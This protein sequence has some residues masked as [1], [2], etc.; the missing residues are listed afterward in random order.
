MKKINLTDY[1]RIRVEDLVISEVTKSLYDYSDRLSEISSLVE[2]ISLIGQQQPIV[3]IKNGP[4]YVIIDGVLRYEAMKRLS[5]N[6]I[7]GIVCEFTETNEFSLSD[8]IIHQQISKQ[9][10][11]TE[12]L[13]EIRT[14]LRVE[15]DDTNPLRDKEKRVLLVSSLL[16]GKGWGRN[17]VYSLDKILRWEVK[18]NSEL[19]LAEKVIANEITV[20]KAVET[21][22][23]L[24]NS[25]FEEEK[26]KES[27]I[28]D[29]FI[30]GAYNAEKAQKLMD[31]YDKK[32]SEGNT[33]IEL[34][35]PVKRNYM[36]IQGNIEEVELP[37]DLQI[38]TIFTSPPYY[39]I[40]KYGDDPNELGWEATPDIYV[41]RLADILMKG[42]EKLKNTGSMFI[43]LGE[44]YEKNSCLAVTDRL[45][46]ELISRGV[47]FVDR[48]IWNKIA[49]KPASNKVKRLLPGYET[50]LHFSKSKDYYFDRV[51]IKSDKTLKV[52]RG[53]K[54][55]SGGLPSY[56][57]PNNYDQFRNVLS[58]EAVSSVLTIQIN[59]NRTKHI[60]GEAYHPATF[61]SNL[62]L[63]PILI[64]TPK[65]RDSVVFDPFLGSGSCGVTSLLLGFKFWGVE[66]YK[67][68]IATAERIL[69]ESQQAFDE[70]SLNSLLEE[71]HLTDDAE[72]LEELNPAA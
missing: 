9:K 57:I 30:K 1:Q 51:R 59:K 24:E 15:K 70:D 16:G 68:N 34:Y 32:K 38:D 21:I 36:I 20:K 46:I 23:L 61:S 29:G 42:Y 58:D 50:I 5:L 8:L 53:C 12:K 44:S 17:N 14:L 4:K 40:I 67:E 41:K 35:K 72:D 27:R 28:V 22:D 52:S 6:E 26:E 63:I 71:Y 49:N 13:N 31:T 56:H 3:V 11:G 60:D 45:T 47:N 19:R 64:S 18:S 10:T 48:L 37:E 69:F 25:R 55:K 66:L 7:D 39:K 33:I 65:D 2:S 62:P 54:E 43:N